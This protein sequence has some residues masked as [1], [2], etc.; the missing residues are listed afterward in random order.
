[1]GTAKTLSI[2]EEDSRVY[3]LPVTDVAQAYMDLVKVFGN[4]NVVLIGGRAVNAQCGFETRKTNDVDFLVD[5]NLTAETIARLQLF[6]WSSSKAHEGCDRGHFER[7][8]SSGNDDTIVIK[9]DINTVDGEDS[10]PGLADK[11][12]VVSNSDKITLV[13]GEF[14]EGV[15]RVAKPSMLVALKLNAIKNLESDMCAKNVVEV[16]KHT[17]DIYWLISKKYGSLDMFIGKE[18]GALDG[19]LLYRMDEQEL[20]GRLRQSYELGKSNSEN[21]LRVREM[22]STVINSVNEKLRIDSLVHAK[23]NDNGEWLASRVDEQLN[24][25]PLAQLIRRESS[26]RDSPKIY[27]EHLLKE[28]SKVYNIFI[29]EL[30]GTENPESISLFAK[31]VSHWSNLPKREL[32]NNL[33]EIIRMGGNRQR[34]HQLA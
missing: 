31:E 19:A 27:P 34:A 3:N 16:A 32:Q 30:G 17:E 26:S 22:H 20:M 33:A 1:M 5:G 12:G 21:Y 29:N 23:I 7:Q 4:G 6:G 2:T 11:K 25:G 15:I 24:G 13:E 18:I 14:F 28:F 8:F 10:L 9:I